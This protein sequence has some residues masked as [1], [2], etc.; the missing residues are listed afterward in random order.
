MTR[1]EKTE[2]LNENSTEDEE[3]TYYPSEPITLKLGDC[4]YWINE[5]LEFKEGEEIPADK[6]TDEACNE[7][8][9]LYV[10]SQKWQGDR[11]ELD[12]V[13]GYWDGHCDQKDYPILSNLKYSWDEEEEVMQA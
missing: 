1:N 8:L 9:M 3:F 4:W 5:I 7:I 10:R 12:D 13:K 11:W 6:L 2:F